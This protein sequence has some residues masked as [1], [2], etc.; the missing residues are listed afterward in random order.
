[1]LKFWFGVILRIFKSTDA[2]SLS[3]YQLLVCRIVVYAQFET[4]NLFQLA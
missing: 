4:L 1:M 2:L 3:D